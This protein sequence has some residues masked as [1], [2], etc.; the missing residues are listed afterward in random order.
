MNQQL[1]CAVIDSNRNHDY[2]LIFG[3]FYSI[4]HNGFVLLDD[5][6]LLDIVIDIFLNIFLHI[7][8]K[9]IN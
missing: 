9:T 2:L 5:L 6:D 1:G 7:T 4:K 3:V 8:D